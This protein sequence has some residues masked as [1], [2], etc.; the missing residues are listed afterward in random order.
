MMAQIDINIQDA[1]RQFQFMRKA[2]L[3][4]LF[5]TLLF[6]FFGPI[7]WVVVAP[8]TLVLVVLC[9]LGLALGSKSGHPRI[10]SVRLAQ[11]TSKAKSGPRKGFFVAIF[12]VVIILSLK[13]AVIFGSPVP[14]PSTFASS[15][16]TIKELEESIR[17]FAY[18]N[19]ILSP[20]LL[21]SV[22]YLLQTTRQKWVNRIFIT[23][24]ILFFIYSSIIVGSGNAIV[25][26]V[27][28]FLLIHLGR[29]RIKASS[30]LK[31]LLAVIIVGL[32]I[33]GILRSRLE[34]LNTITMPV[35]P[36]QGIVDQFSIKDA[37]VGQFSVY[38]L[39]R[40]LTQGYQ[41]MQFGQA[42]SPQA[43]ALPFTSSRF[44]VR[45][46]QRFGVLSEKFI[47]LEE[48]IN[49]TAGWRDRQQWATTFLW[50]REDVPT[51]LLPLLSYFF[52]KFFRNVTMVFLMMPSP[53][54][55]AQSMLIVRIILFLPLNAIFVATGEELVRSTV[56]LFIPSALLVMASIFRYFESSMLVSKPFPKRSL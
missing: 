14:P 1:E 52:G 53:F 3:V 9:Y 44:M 45:Q 8:W 13:N 43:L 34:G 47:S 10:V 36:N 21:L 46:Y 20:L 26:M 4:Y 41:G 22:C 35:I 19:F 38:M 11:W 40:Y 15:Y 24:A 2:L 39:S 56:F 49:E 55:L 33:A 54:R 37:N 42:V 27:L 12:G 23:L 32:S 7:G 30:Y 48:Q 25:E 50:L 31:A 28:L 6:Y 17:G 18:V 51:I 5:G 16:S 29:K